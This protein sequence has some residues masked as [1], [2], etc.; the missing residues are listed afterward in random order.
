MVGNNISGLQN[1]MAFIIVFEKVSSFEHFAICICTLIF[2]FYLY[3]V[4]REIAPILSI[5]LRIETSSL[6]RV[7]LGVAHK[8]LIWSA[9]DAF[10]LWEEVLLPIVKLK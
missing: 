7:Y 3:S 1:L 4:Q 5:P 8:T 2:I 6:S 10:S 9:H